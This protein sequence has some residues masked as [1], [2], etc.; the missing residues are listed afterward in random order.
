MLA[1]LNKVLCARQHPC[2]ALA[3]RFTEVPSAVAQIDSGALKGAQEIARS[4]PVRPSRIGQKKLA[5]IT[6]REVRACSTTS[7]S[8]EVL[9]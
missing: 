7:M 8:A 9:G 6:G 3:G 5:H 2:K 1:I 4:V